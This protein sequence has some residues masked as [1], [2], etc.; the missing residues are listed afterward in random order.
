M[1]KAA[2]VYAKQSWR[3][4]PHSA[5][6]Q[7]K[8]QSSQSRIQPSKKTQGSTDLKSKSC[9]SQL[10]SMGKP[11]EN[12]SGGCQSRTQAIVSVGGKGLH[13]GGGGKEKVRARPEWCSVDLGHLV[14]SEEDEVVEPCASHLPGGDGGQ[15]PACKEAGL[16]TK[17]DKMK[18]HFRISESG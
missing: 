1:Q 18:G 3:T 11:S 2:Q 16:A 17:E 6:V 8:P 13:D 4:K 7:N 10:H 5:A 14:R 9:H 12:L 15:G